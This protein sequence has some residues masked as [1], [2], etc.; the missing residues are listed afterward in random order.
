M[1]FTIQ[2]LENIGLTEIEAKCYYQLLSYGSVSASIISRKTNIPRSTVRLALDWLYEKHLVKVAKEWNT[3][4]YT[5]EHPNTLYTLITKQ[6]SELQKK[7]ERLKHEISNLS[8]IYTPEN[9]QAVVTY[10][11]W[12]EGMKKMLT[13]VTVFSWKIFS[14]SWAEYF[15]KYYPKV[16][17]RFREYRFKN[18]KTSA[19]YSLRPQTYL[20]QKFNENGEKHRWYTYIDEF[21]ID[22]QI[23]GENVVITS[24]DWGE[25]IAIHIEHEKIADGMKRLFEEIYKLNAK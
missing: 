10:Y 9:K 6:E 4:L 2:N 13:Q 19:N 14:F 21:P 7:K 16:I 3:K 11:H 24:V 15:Q 22:I 8:K 20:N 18:K 25:P 5:A 23:Y 17:E 12:F 1:S